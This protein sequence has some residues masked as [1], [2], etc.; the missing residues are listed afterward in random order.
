MSETLDVGAVF[1]PKEMVGKRVI[2]MEVNAE[3]AADEVGLLVRPLILSRG[4]HH[5]SH[6]ADHQPECYPPGR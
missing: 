5:D 3:L 2:V 1:L 6:P 4:Q